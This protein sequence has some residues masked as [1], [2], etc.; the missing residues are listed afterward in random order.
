MMFINGVSVEALG[1]HL[2]EGYSVSGA[3]LTNAYHKGKN[4]T[5][6]V[7]LSS[8]IGLKTITLPIAIIGDNQAE[9]T[10]RKLTM[11]AGLY[12][13]NEIWLPDGYFYTTILESMGEP[14]FFG[15][16]VLECTYVLSGVQHDAKI[17]TTGPVVFCQ[18]TIPRTDCVLTTTVKQAAA[19][20]TFDGAM[21]AN[22][23]AGDVL[24]L[25]GQNGRVLIN[26]GPGAQRCD[27]VEFPYLVP[28]QNVISAPDT[29]IVEYYP[30]YL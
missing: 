11:D 13:K 10:R 5:S 16:T 20:Y 21:F 18:S 27:F 19:S 15:E 24:C 12:G 7:L 22:V 3:P 29:V 1:A 4:R 25:D 28:G 30:T 8:E 17:Q 6:F 2:K 26:G 23:K 9:L 14:V